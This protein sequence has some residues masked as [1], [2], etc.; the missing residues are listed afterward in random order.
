MVSFGPFYTVKWPPKLGEAG[1]SDKSDKAPQKGNVLRR[2]HFEAIVS[3]KIC[4]CAIHTVKRATANFWG[5]NSF[6]IIP[7]YLGTPGRPKARFVAVAGAHE[8]RR[9][10]YGVKVAKTDV[11]STA[12]TL[13]KSLAQ[14]GAARTGFTVRRARVSQGAGPGGR[15]LSLDRSTLPALGGLTVRRARGPRW[16]PERPGGAG[17]DTDSKSS[18]Q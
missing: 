4:S 15:A 8:L 14:S 5:H 1:H 7:S 6:K 3:P 12:P 9:P 10:L 13:P 2:N 16:G 18:A 17:A 11:R